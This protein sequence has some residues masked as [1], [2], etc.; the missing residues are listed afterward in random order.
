MRAAVTVF[1]RQGFQGTKIQDVAAEA[2]VVTTAVNYHFSSKDELYEAALE[3]VFRQLD[4]VVEEVRSPEGEVSFH[5]V[6][7]AM[8]DWVENNPEPA[9]LLYHQLPGATASS[10]Q[11]RQDFERR[12]IERVLDHGRSEP[13]NRRHTALRWTVTSL[14]MRSLLALGTN[15]QS[16]RLNDGPLA[17]PST[18]TL[19][20]A[21]E[22]VS[23]RMISAAEKR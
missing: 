23:L 1:A 5:G 3:S 18:A 15:V 10:L 22:A 13:S 17:G 19:R 9:N 20:T 21:C 14:I 12:Q 8:W 7:G 11:I 16:L 6:I 2:H 4:E